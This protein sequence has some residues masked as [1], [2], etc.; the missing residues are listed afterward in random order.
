MHDIS[1]KMKT[2]APAVL[3]IGMSLVILWFGLEQIL[4]AS[5][6]IG[7]LPAWTSALPWPQETII[8]LNGSFEILLGAFMLAGLY[9]PQLLGAD[10][11]PCC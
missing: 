4:D 10:C 5:S 11:H 7:Y 3:R 1:I 2:A 8:H 9:T 6:W